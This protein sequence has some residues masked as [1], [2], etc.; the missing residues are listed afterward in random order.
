MIRYY[1]LNS[2]FYRKHSKIDYFSVESS[3]IITTHSFL[4]AFT[5]TT[6][7]IYLNFLLNMIFVVYLATDFDP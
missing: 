3:L 7:I 1:N 4:Q 6:F 2:V 5:L